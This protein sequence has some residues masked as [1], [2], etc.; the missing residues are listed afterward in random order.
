MART[1][2]ARLKKLIKFLQLERRSAILSGR[3]AGAFYGKEGEKSKDHYAISFK[4]DKFYYFSANESGHN[5]D[6]FDITNAT[7]P[8]SKELVKVCIDRLTE[9][10]LKE[11]RERM[12]DEELG[13]LQRQA[14]ARLEK[15]L[16]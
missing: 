3:D 12:A 13:R 8:A 10:A 11:V 6:Y 5:G 14:K 1:D 4:D 2:I 9:Y 7:L 15:E 16:R